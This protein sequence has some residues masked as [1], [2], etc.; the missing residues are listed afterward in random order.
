[1]AQKLARDD[2]NIRLAGADDVVSL[3]RRRYHSYCAGQNL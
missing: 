2:G 3:G 1:V